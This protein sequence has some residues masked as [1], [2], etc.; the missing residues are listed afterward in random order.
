MSSGKGEQLPLASQIGESRGEEPLNTVVRT[1]GTRE[2]PSDFREKHP[3]IDKTGMS[4]DLLTNTPSKATHQAS[5]LAQ[6]QRTFSPIRNQPQ[7]GATGGGLARLR[8]LGRVGSKLS[9]DDGDVNL[10]PTDRQ[11]HT[12]DPSISFSNQKL[13]TTETFGVDPQQRRIVGEAPGINAVKDKEVGPTALA[14]SQPIQSEEFA[15]LEELRPEIDNIMGQF[16]HQA[17]NEANSGHSPSGTTL[18]VF[19]YPPRTSSLE[20]HQKVQTSGN[21]QVADEGGEISPMPAGDPEKFSLSRTSTVSQPP[22]PEPDPEP[23][24]PFDFHRF[25]E[26]LRHRTADPVAK[27]LRSFL[28]EFGKK[29]WMVHEQVK[30]IGDFLSFIGHRMAQCDVWRHV[31]EAEFDN[32]KEGMEKL[33]MNRL[34]NQ[35]FSPEIPATEPSKSRLKGANITLAPGRKGQHQEDVERDDVLAQKVR[36]YGWVREE[37]LDIKHFGDKGRKFLSLAQKG[38]QSFMSRYNPRANQINRTCKE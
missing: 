31:S 7:G 15:G 27:F 25:L 36:I 4:S 11:V 3:A 14:G 2:L 20:H 34:Y 30:I 1:A 6:E 18:P 12:D 26:Q 5:A 28:Q 29:Q 17:I 8:A 33:V 37:H 32:A 19:H 35:T 21:S 16:K 22:P 24:L 9:N 38:A 13:K 10:T 23:D